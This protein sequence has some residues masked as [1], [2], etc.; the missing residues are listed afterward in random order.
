MT[1]KDITLGVL[2]I[3]SVV[4]LVGLKIQQLDVNKRY[5]SIRS[6]L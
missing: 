1:S 5:I 6:N 4:T 3:K 2:I